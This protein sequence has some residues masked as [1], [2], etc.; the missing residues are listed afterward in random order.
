MSFLSETANRL[1][2][3]TMSHIAAVKRQLIADGKDVIDLGAGDA[4][5]PVPEI[6]VQTLAEAAGVPAMSRY[7]HQVGLAEF[8]EAAARYMDRRFGVEVDPQREI[9][10]LIGSKEGLAHLP[11]AVLDPGDICIVP[12]PGYPAYVGGATLARAELEFYPLTPRTDFLIELDELSHERLDRTGLVYLNYPN[13]PTAAVAPM[14]YLERTVALCRERR[15][16]LAY[17]NPYCEITFDGYRAP[18]ILEVAGARDIALEFHSLSKSFS[19]TGWRIAWAV[20]NADLIAALQKVKTYL[21]TGV[22]LAVQKAA[23]A[24][25]DQ[26]EDLVQP[27]RDTLRGRRDAAVTAFGEI[28]LSVDPPRATMYLWVPLPE[29]VSSAA[30]AEAALREEAVAVV[31]GSSFGPAGEGFFRIA[32]TVGEERMN[33]AISRMARTLDGMGVRS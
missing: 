2:A 7:P 11:M 18:S 27:V 4:D 3:Y 25:L 15:I 23:A 5:L 20:G 10:P 31:A 17:D 30:F 1:P 12:Q 16:V 22:F 33:Q 6:A 21:D 19:M 29:G 9:L 8:R 28:G 26:A 24:V 14:D 13:N 32:L